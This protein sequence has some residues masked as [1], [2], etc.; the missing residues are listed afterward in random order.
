MNDTVGASGRP[1]LPARGDRAM[2]V[3]RDEECERWIAA[4]ARRIRRQVDAMA[5]AAPGARRRAQAQ[6]PAH[7]PDESRAEGPAGE[8]RWRVGFATRGG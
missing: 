7:E 4:P 8:G 5:G 6:P 1:D 3:M 2:P